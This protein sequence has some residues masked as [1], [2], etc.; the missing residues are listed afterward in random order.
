MPSTPRGYPYP[1]E[2]DLIGAYPAVAKALAQKLQSERVSIG[3]TEVVT[4]SNEVGKTVAVDFPAGLFTSP[5]SVVVTPRGTFSYFGISTTPTTTGVG[6]G[7]A[8]KGT[9]NVSGSV[10]VSW[11]A[12]GV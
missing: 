6:V 4:L 11:V 1:D 12:T 9:A 7:V 10:T 3:G 2:N 5:P 8:S